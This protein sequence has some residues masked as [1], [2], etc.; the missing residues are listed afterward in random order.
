MYSSPF[1]TLTGMASAVQLS[2]CLK[3]RGFMPFPERD[4]N[5]TL[6]GGARGNE[7]KMSGI[8]EIVKKNQ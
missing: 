1:V 6:E 2:L 7:W 5:V 3:A 8:T 4:N